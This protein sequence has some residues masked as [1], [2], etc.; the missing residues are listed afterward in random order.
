MC[1]IVKEEND[2]EGNE[3]GWETVGSGKTDQQHVQRRR[4]QKS[5]QA[6]AETWSAFKRHPD[7][8]QYMDHAKNA[9]NVEPTREEL[10][11]LS[12]ACS[13]L[14]ELDLNR[15][16]PGKDYE[17]N[18]GGGKKVSQK[19]D[20]ASEC[21]FSWLSDDILRRP[22]YSRFCSLLDNYNPDQRC[23]EVVTSEEKQ[24][25]TAFIEE[26]SRTAPVKY[27][28]HYLV[29][30]EIISDN[31][32]NFKRM[33]CGLWFDLY[34]RGGVS[35]SSSAFEHVFVGEIKRR[36]VK[37]F[38]LEEAKGTVDYQG[39]ILPRRRGPCIF[40]P[41]MPPRPAKKGSGGST[42]ARKTAARTAKG[43]LKA[44]NQAEVSEDPPKAEE[45]RAPVEEVKEESKVEEV[46]V[47][48]TVQEK[49]VVLDSSQNDP[50]SVDVEYEDVKEV[51]SEEDK[52]ERLELED[53]EPEYE[54]EEDTAVDYDEKYPEN[55][56][57]ED[58]VDEGQEGDEGDMVEEEEVDMGDEEIEDGGEDLEGEEEFENAEE[59]QIDAEED[60]HEVVEEHRKR[61]EF[62]V[63]VGGLDKD[64]NEDD[65]KK[66]FSQVGEITEIRLMMNPITKKNKGFAFLRF[67]TVEQAKRAVSELKNPV[68][69]GKQCGVAPSQDSDTLFVG[70]IC[71]SWTR[72]HFKEKLKSYGVENMEDLTLVEDTNNA[73]MNRGF[74]FLEFSSRSEA[75]DAYRCLQKRDV[76]FGV[77][78]TA[79]IAFADSFIEPD[80]EIMAQVKTVFIDGLPA[81]W[82]EDRVKDYLKKYGIIEKV[83]LARN[84]PAAKRKDF[85]FVTFDS[86]DNAVACAEG[87]NNAELGEGNDKVK[88]RARLSRPHQRGRVKHDPR[89]IFRVGRGAPRGGR[90]P[91]GRPPPRR[92]PSYAPRSIIARGMPIGGRGLRRPFGY[93]DR[94]SVMA[95]AERAR[96]LPPPERAIAEY[97]SRVPTERHLSYRDDYSPRGPG[98]MDIPARNA[99]R[100]GDRRT[101]IDDGYERKLERPVT[102][103]REGR[104]RDYDSISGSKRPYSDL[105]DTRYADASLRQSRA[106]LDYAVSGSGSQYGDAYSDRLGRSHMGYSGSRS[107]VSG[108]DSLYGNRQGMTYGGGSVSGS[109]AGGM[110]SS[111]FNGGY[112]SRGSDIGGGSSSSASFYSGRNLSSIW[113]FMTQ[114]FLFRLKM[115]GGLTGYVNVNEDGIT[116]RV[117]RYSDEG[118][119]GSLPALVPDQVRKLKQLTVLTLAETEKVLPYD[120]LMEELDVSNVRELEDFLINECMYA[121]IVRGKLD[122]L[123]RCFE[124]QFAAGRD[125]RPEQLDNMI[126]TLSD[127]LG[128]SDSLLHL[129]QEKI[130]WADIMSETNKKHKKEIEDKVEEVKKSL[131]ADLDLRGHEESFSESGGMMDYEEDRVRPKR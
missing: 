9:V 55:E 27:L 44:K 10:D 38:Y 66:V 45:T 36:K 49:P 117:G 26:I 54:P 120:Q 128:T 61:K 97:G 119:A 31:Y 87:I 82:D 53:N 131:K 13:R 37:E 56:I 2:N 3:G 113:S 72:E 19:G 58:D 71:K 21:L 65:L 102:T 108:H 39:Y 77:D 115:A 6:P 122:Q 107:S 1:C 46:V 69:R 88:V 63:F 64:A 124:V 50:E 109:G 7:E 118:N 125:L 92:F 48:K 60:H 8:Q 12:N 114:V 30:K 52:N 18:C 83:E 5:W 62:E 80:D 103:Y 81:V 74:A 34:G 57:I 15:L 14:W 99:S 106:R 29:S 90:V 96:R 111:S 4:P 79:K 100:P 84:M 32:E 75:M 23:K 67:A 85:G 110:Y 101:F 25:Q 116:I 24:E 93:R 47:E 94:H 70:N 22:T 91:Y 95:V 78:R 104:S 123:R 121:G 112:M 130:K 16:V 86:H 68:V 59:D 17:I 20:M 105:D 35:D 98:Y 28:Y 42:G 126:Q 43:T 73:G 76:V 40:G 51:Y 33:M 89:G 129:I 11:D 127:W 41:E